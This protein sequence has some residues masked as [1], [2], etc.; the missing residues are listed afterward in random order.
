MPNIIAGLVTIHY[1]VLVRA[2]PLPLVNLVG[3]FGG[4]EY[5]RGRHLGTM[6]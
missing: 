6:N 2:L 1:N 5:N 4:R 3:T